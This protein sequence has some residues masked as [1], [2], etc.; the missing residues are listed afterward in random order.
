VTIELLQCDPDEVHG[1][2]A[3]SGLQLPRARAHAGGF[4]VEVEMP[5]VT[6]ELEL[7]A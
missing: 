3:E 6:G 1:T 4:G 2:V 5:V 7:V